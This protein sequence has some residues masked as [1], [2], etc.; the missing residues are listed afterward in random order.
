MVSRGTRLDGLEDDQRAVHAAASQLFRGSRASRREGHG[1]VRPARSRSAAT[2]GAQLA[3]L[4]HVRHPAVGVA[5]HA[6]LDA[7]AVA[8]HEHRDRHLRAS[9]TARSGRSPRACRGTRPRPASRSPSSPR[10]ARASAAARRRVGAVVE[11]LRRVPAGADAEHEPPAGQVVERRDDLGRARSGRARSRG[12][13]RSR[14]RASRSR[15]R[16]TRA[17]RTGRACAGTVGERPAVARD[18]PGR[19]RDVRVSVTH[20][21]LVAAP[22]RRRWAARRWIPRRSGRSRAPTSI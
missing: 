19:D 6:V 9:A 14:R 17:R 20:Q 8:A 21:R 12:T 18:H 13:P 4:L 3:Q 10:R 7:R 2:R 15:P 16:R 1:H 11:H 5:Q 22:P